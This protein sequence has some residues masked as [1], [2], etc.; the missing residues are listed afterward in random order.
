MRD[1]DYLQ[2]VLDKYGHRVF[3]MKNKKA[4]DDNIYIGRPTE[5]GN[6][7]RTAENKTLQDRMSNCI[8][9][10]N[11]LFTI[12]NGNINPVLIEKIKNMVDKN[13]IC[14]CSNGTC[15]MAEGGQFCHGHV[16]LY[17]ADYLNGKPV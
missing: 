5:F 1:A 9:F 7:Y 13:V 4:D 14:W 16:L 6:P 8:K 12:I 10:R 17:A 15:S 3:S 2:M 11:N